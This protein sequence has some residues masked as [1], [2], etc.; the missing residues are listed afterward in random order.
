MREAR[1]K[2]GRREL[3]GEEEGPQLLRRWKEVATPVGDAARG[4]IK[5]WR[6]AV[7]VTI[8]KNLVEYT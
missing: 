6:E 7:F 5:V 8:C 2:H 4:A 1:G 3:T